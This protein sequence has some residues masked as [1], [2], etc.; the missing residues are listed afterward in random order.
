MEIKDRRELH[1][2]RVVLNNEDKA[3]AA[4][5]AVV[6]L[7]TGKRSKKLSK[8]MKEVEAELQDIQDKLK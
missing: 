2:R 8:L 1:K 3:L 6:R 4:A 5:Q 7:R